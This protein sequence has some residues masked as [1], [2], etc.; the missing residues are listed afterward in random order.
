MVSTAMLSERTHLRTDSK[1]N[2]EYSLPHSEFYEW[3]KSIFTET[4]DEQNERSQTQ[5]DPLSPLGATR[6]YLERRN[7][8]MAETGQM[9]A[10][11][12]EGLAPKPPKPTTCQIWDQCDEGT[13]VVFC[14]VAPGTA[15]GTANATL[16]AHVL[17]E[18]ASHLNTPS[19]AWR[20]FKSL[21]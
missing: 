12:F 11:H 13:Q 3:K 15:H 17:Y 10:S 14:K 2:F 16:D 1:P 21:W 18:N 9:V 5:L 20:F 19:V 7:Y 4:I 6:T 8:L